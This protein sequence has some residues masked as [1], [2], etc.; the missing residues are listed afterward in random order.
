[1]KKSFRIFVL[2]AITLLSSCSNQFYTGNTAL[3]DV[4]LQ[5]NSSEYEIKR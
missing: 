2:A 4:S 1:M 3:S 5:R